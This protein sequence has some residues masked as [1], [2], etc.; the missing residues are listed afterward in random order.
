[1]GA[2]LK[3][4]RKLFKF[5]VGG[6]KEDF[7][8]WCLKRI[9]RGLPSSRL[10]LRN[11][12][13]HLRKWYA[14]ISQRET[15]FGWGLSKRDNGWLLLELRKNSKGRFIVFSHFAGVVCNNLLDVHCKQ[16]M[17]WT[18]RSCG[19]WDIYA[20]PLGDEEPLGDEAQVDR[21]RTLWKKGEEVRS[22]P[23]VQGQAVP[24]S[25]CCMTTPN[26]TLS[27]GS[28]RKASSNNATALL[29]KKLLTSSPNTNP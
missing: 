25:G 27:R 13:G 28:A 20:A 23:S 29:S 18:C 9:E 3:V 10:G 24:G 5:V 22:Q 21:S 1:M 2:R 16:L 11:S 7:L 26:C 12:N 14:S 19:S 8:L 6:D 17:G 15:H 4:D